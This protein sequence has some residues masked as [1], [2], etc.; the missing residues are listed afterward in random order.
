[1]SRV[2]VSTHPLYAGCRECSVYILTYLPNF[3]LIAF[4]KQAYTS[5]VAPL[6]TMA[7]DVVDA[8]GLIRAFSS[9]SLL[10]V[11]AEVVHPDG[12]DKPASLQ[13]LCLNIYLCSTESSVVLFL[14]CKIVTFYTL[15]I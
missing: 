7:L 11:K 4:F 9:L 13:V 8:S 1:M 15:P 3:P 14:V 6:V 12:V 2:Y 5:S 10:H